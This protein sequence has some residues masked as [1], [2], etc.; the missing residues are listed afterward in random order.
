MRVQITK[1]VALILLVLL[2]APAFLI[3]Q[4]INA[5]SSIPTASCPSFDRSNF[6][7]STQITN[8]YSP[9]KQGAVFVYSGIVEGQPEGIVVTV[10]NA[11]RIVDGVSTVVLNDTVK[12]NGQT[13]E[14]TRDYYAQDT[15]GNVWYFGEDVLIIKNGQVVGHNGSWLAGVNGAQPGYI[16]EASPKV[17]DFYCNENAPG[18]AQ[19]QAQVLSVSS[20]VC[21]PYVCTDKQVL[22][23][24]DTS[25]II[26]GSVEHVWYVAGVGKVLTKDVVGGQDEV[27]LD[28]VLAIDSG[29]QVAVSSTSTQAATGREASVLIM[30]QASTVILGILL[31]ISAAVSLSRRGRERV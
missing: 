20:S 30:Y 11:T 10:T 16:M 28:A 9:M 31:V 5:K 26:P 1:G 29:S 2:I 25:P 7:K 19:D 12:V 18:V 15:S 27:Q 13:T 23:I 14:T 4:P 24:N 3:S 6:P 17:G 22:L 8:P 21:T